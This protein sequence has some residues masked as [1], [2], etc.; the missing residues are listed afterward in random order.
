MVVNSTEIRRREGTT[1]DI[2]SGIGAIITGYMARKKAKEDPT[3]Y[4]GEGMA[5][6]GMI[7]GGVF[8]AVSLIYWIVVVIF[9]G[10]LI[11]SQGLR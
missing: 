9:Y 6:A 11:A 1:L 10:S 8:T 2:E 5:L 3:N 4:G 7:C